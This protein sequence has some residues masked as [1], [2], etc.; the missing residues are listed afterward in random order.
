VVD[1]VDAVLDY[2]GI[3][4]F[5]SWGVSG[6]GPHVLACAALMPERVVAA[7]CISGVAPYSADGLD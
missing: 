2:L 1:D 7:A 3:D 6:G 5:A 4:R